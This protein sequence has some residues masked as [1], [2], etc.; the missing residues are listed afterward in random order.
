M[1]SIPIQTTQ[2]WGV[3]PIRAHE[4]VIAAKPINKRWLVFR[5]RLQTAKLRELRELAAVNELMRKAVPLGPR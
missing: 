5:C 4:T 2:K 3:N 1:A